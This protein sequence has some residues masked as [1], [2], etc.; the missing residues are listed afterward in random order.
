MVRQRGRRARHRHDPAEGRRGALRIAAGVADAA[1]LSFLAFG[2]K[3]PQPSA[4]TAQV[5][6]V[7]A[8]AVVGL[9]DYCPDIGHIVSL[10]DV[11]LSQAIHTLSPATIKDDPTHHKLIRRS[12]DTFRYRNWD[13]WVHIH[14]QL[15][16]FADVNW[17]AGATSRQPVAPLSSQPGHNVRVAVGAAPTTGADEEV[18]A[19]QLTR[20]GVRL[21]PRS[22]HPDL[23]DRAKLKDPDP[24]KPIDEWLKTAL[25]NR[26]R[27][28][29]T[30]YLKARTF[31]E[32]GDKKKG[33]KFFPRLLG[34]RWAFR[35]EKA[36]QAGAMKM[37]AFPE[38]VLVWPPGS[39]DRTATLDKIPGNLQ[40]YHNKI[41]KDAAH[42]RCGGIKPPELKPG[43]SHPTGF[44]DD[45][46]SDLDDM[47]WPVSKAD[48]P[49][50]RE[51][52]FTQVQ[53]EHFKQWSIDI[54]PTSE[55]PFFKLIVPLPVLINPFLTD[56][57]GQL[58]ILL[59]SS[60]KFVPALIDMAN[61][62]SMLGGSFL[63]GI[64][65]G[66]EG[67]RQANWTLYHGGTEYFPDVRF[68]LSTKTR[69][70]QA[71][72]PGML[73][74]ISPFPGRRITPP[75]TRTIGRRPGRSRQDQCGGRGAQVVITRAEITPPGAINY[76]TSYWKS[77][78]SSAAWI[79]PRPGT[80]RCSSKRRSSPEP[81]QGCPARFSSSWAEG[82]RAPPSPSSRRRT[83]R[84]RPSSRVT[85]TSGPALA[86]IW[87]EPFAERWARSACRAPKAGRSPCRA[88]A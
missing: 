84:A 75:A 26:L 8:W 10:W 83:E 56:V 13:Y 14:P 72:L 78:A 44:D 12:T 51:L 81:S 16:I 47:Y 45:M 37:L 33:P 70:R 40:D 18:M 5:D 52:A 57:D 68:E 31:I 79:R 23:E 15:C 36:N 60:P 49:L 65:V 62:G 76:F 48:M 77:S 61:L 28:P 66:L 22:M 54:G 42:Q 59:T 64:E 2:T 24:K 11:A 38:S 67:A 80:S 87:P 32:D 55:D 73:T 71:A 4:S 58:T 63:P 34:R 25:F 19:V 35:P 53:F 7:P 17:V 21:K 82:R 46:L 27:L 20:G 3:D 50:L 43:E 88:P 1:E 69:R 39:V 41:K 9:P 30:L 74:K 29:G 85:T 86:S 6:C